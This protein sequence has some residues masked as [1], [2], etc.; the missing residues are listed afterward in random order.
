MCARSNGYDTYV[1]YLT[2]TPTPSPPGMSV[3]VSKALGTKGYGKMR[4]SAIYHTGTDLPEPKAEDVQWTYDAQFKYRWTDKH[5][6]S[7]VVD[8][9]PGVPQ[10]FRCVV[11]IILRASVG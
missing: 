7:A 8:V 6:R 3:R 10:V 11:N 4:L 2:Q 1:S 5:L 9:T